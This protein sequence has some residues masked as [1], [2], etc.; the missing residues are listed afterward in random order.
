VRYYAE[1]ILKKVFASQ[2]KGTTAQGIRESYT[3][4]RREGWSGKP[5][6][7]SESPTS[8]RE[9][10]NAL[11]KGKSARARNAVDYGEAK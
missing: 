8:R 5:Q 1:R 9:N 11:W 6:V 10:M 7:C 2:C 3:P 4:R